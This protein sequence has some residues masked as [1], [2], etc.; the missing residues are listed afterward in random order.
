MYEILAVL[1]AK[2]YRFSTKQL[3]EWT[4]KFSNVVDYYFAPPLNTVLHLP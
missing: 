3:C 1:A 2:P 4:S